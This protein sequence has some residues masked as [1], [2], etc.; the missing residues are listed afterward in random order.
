MGDRVVVICTG[1]EKHW[2]PTRSKRAASRAT[3][4]LRRRP[5]I[6]ML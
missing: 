6:V 2:T 4:Q 3:Q 1:G 5:F